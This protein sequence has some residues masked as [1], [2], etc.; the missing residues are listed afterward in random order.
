MIQTVF[1]VLL[2]IIQDSSLIEDYQKKKNKVFNSKNN[3]EQLLKLADW[4]STNDLTLQKEECFNEVVRTDPGNKKA[5]EVLGYKLENSEWIKTQERLFLE[6]VRRLVDEKIKFVITDDVLI[7]SKTSKHVKKGIELLTYK[8]YWVR[9]LLKIN[10]MLKF[11]FDNLDLI[12]TVAMDDQPGFGHGFGHKGKGEIM[13]DVKSFEKYSRMLS[14]LYQD[15]KAKGGRI[16]YM[17]FDIN[18]AITHELIHTFATFVGVS[19]IDEGFASYMQTDNYHIR[20]FKLFS[21]L[22]KLTQNDYK[23]NPQWAYGRG[24]LFWTF[25]EK[26][27]GNDVLIELLSSVRYGKYIPAVE[28]VTGKKWEEIVEQEFQWSKKFL[29]KIEIY[30][31]LQ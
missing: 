24:A 8:E 30:D 7:Q 27:F 17:R 1:I 3:K 4:C 6:D 13:F 22:K 5:R 29:T 12:V 21:T 18:N 11:G 14:E 25:I 28:K 2:F 20:V 9:S 10:K 26:E 16:R 31:V 23:E 15:K 19:W